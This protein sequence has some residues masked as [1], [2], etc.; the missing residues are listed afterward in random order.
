MWV[1][2]REILGCDFVAAWAL[3]CSA[4]WGVGLFGT[5]ALRAGAW[6][7]MYFVVFAA[8]FGGYIRCGVVFRGPGVDRQSRKSIIPND[9]HHKFQRFYLL[10]LILKT[11]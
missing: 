2:Q 5:V 4:C 7:A 1:G 11:A 9:R 6:A 3:G 10:C 8:G